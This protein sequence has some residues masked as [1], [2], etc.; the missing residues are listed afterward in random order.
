MRRVD[1][2]AQVLTHEELK[3]ISRAIFRHRIDKPHDHPKLAAQ[4]DPL[5]SVAA[6]VSQDDNVNRKEQN[7]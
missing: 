7:G 5:V 2:L 1:Q 4:L 6:S 3:Y